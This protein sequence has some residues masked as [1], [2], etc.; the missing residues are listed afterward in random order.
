MI[1]GR[2]FGAE[3]LGHL[4]RFTGL[5]FWDENFKALRFEGFPT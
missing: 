4:S 1:R 3:G 5:G 2:G